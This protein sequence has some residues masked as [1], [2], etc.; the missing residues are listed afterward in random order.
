[1]LVACWMVK[2]TP[3]HVNHATTQN[4]IKSTGGYELYDF[5]APR[6]EAFKKAGFESVE[7]RRD[8]KA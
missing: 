2:I 4:G 7:V 1:M 6:E 3:I 5:Y 8:L